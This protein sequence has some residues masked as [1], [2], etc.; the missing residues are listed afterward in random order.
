M[1]DRDAVE[2]LRRML[3]ISSLSGKESELASFLAKQARTAGLHSAVDETGNLV[4][5]SGGDPLR[6]A[7]GEHDIVLLGHMD[8]VEGEIPVRLEGD[9]LFGRGAVDAKGPLA[10][11]LCAA[12]SLQGTLPA[13]VRLVVIGAVEEETPTSR[14]A[15][16]V[17]D[18]YQPAACLIGE[19]SGWDGVTLGYKGR[20]VA[21]AALERPGGHSAGPHGS[22]ADA[23]V[24]WWNAARHRAA[25]LAA[26]TDGPFGQVQATLRRFQTSHDGLRDRAELSCGFRL[27]PGVPPDRVRALCQEEAPREMSLRFEGGEAAVV[28][29]RASSVARALT[30]AVRAQGCRP[31][32]VYKTGTS[33]MNVVA[34]A[35][36]CPIAAYG[37]GDS[38]LDH[39]PNEHILVSE[40][41][42]AI[43]VLRGA[44]TALA[45][46]GL[47]R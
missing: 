34:P 29:D 42:R 10:A 35:W 38:A 6:S 3:E 7:A 2:L 15:R 37:P 16:A 13:G 32:L 21:H 8:T 1:N 30:G 17:V 4:A 11:F 5:A 18:R 19:P 20:L 26:G 23:L 45:T 31:R 27:P 41:L 36:N 14:G 46:D 12:A 9:S 24:A 33:D 22:A 43:A 47:S 40:Y 39:T 25:G 44:L 28:A